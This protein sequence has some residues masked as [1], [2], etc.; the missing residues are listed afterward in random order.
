MSGPSSLVL[1]LAMLAAGALVWGGIRLI[2][3]GG[4]QRT[5]G[6]LMLVCAAVIAGN[7]LIWTV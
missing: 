7:V 5:K 3:R 1:S 4:A 2:R 6:M